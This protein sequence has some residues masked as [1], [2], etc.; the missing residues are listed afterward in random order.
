MLTC[1]NGDCCLSYLPHKLRKETDPPSNAARRE[2][3]L[4]RILN[5]GTPYFTSAQAKSRAREQF[6]CLGLKLL[7]QFHNTSSPDPNKVG[8]KNVRISSSNASFADTDASATLQGDVPLPKPGSI[9][10]PRR[11]SSNGLAVGNWA[12]T[13]FA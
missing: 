1:R 6:L 8:N 5:L 2:S 4:V 9:H 7:I 10:S 12:N 13:R 11:I 3:R